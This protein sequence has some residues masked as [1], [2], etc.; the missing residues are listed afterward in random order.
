M[1][2]IVKVFSLLSDETRLR[3]L[4]VLTGGESCV[5]EVTKAL[6]ITQST[7]SRGL[8]ALYD[9]GLLKLRKEGPWSLYA[10]NWEGMTPYQAQL[11][12][13]T[14][15]EMAHDP[16]IAGDRQKLAQAQRES[17]RAALAPR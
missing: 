3:I 16:L 8:T 5:C 11:V 6:G 7:A 10:L 17:P 1:K 12:R 15:A 13:L 14:T 4:N 2:N 9:A